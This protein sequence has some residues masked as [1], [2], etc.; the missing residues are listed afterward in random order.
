M[1]PKDGVD[2]IPRCAWYVAD[3]HPFFAEQSVDQGRLTNVGPS[4][5]RNPR[6]DAIRTQSAIGL[7]STLAELVND[8]IE[9]FG[10]PRPVFRRNFKDRLKTKLI[11]LVAQSA[12]VLVI[13]L[14]DRQE[15]RSAERSHGLRDHLVG[16]QYSFSPVHEKHDQVGVS[17]RLAA[18]LDDELTQWIVTGS[19]HPSCVNK[20][21]RNSLPDSGLLDDVSGRPGDRRDNGSPR[22]H[23]AVKK[24]R[25]ADVWTADEDNSRSTN[26]HLAPALTA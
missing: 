21:E 14:V 4:H 6:V 25:F 18:V 5:D 20:G 10:N 15:H 8:S 9:E 19:K 26:W 23:N 11:K 3:E 24:C 1:P 2:G 13:R 17:E 12:R 7:E 16:G 22:P